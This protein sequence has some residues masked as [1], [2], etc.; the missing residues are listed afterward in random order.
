MQ[1]FKIF[2][3]LINYFLTKYIFILLK[4]FLL[5]KLYIFITEKLATI[6]N[7]KILGDY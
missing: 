1:T 7:K 5:K 2:F 6:G 3:I 4:I